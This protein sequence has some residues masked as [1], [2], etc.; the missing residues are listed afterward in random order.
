MLSS[1][2]T[3]VSVMYKTT[4]RAPHPRSQLGIAHKCPEYLPML[5]ISLTWDRVPDS[6][7]QEISDLWLHIQSPHFLP[8]LFALGVILIVVE[9]VILVKK[10]VPR[11]N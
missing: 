2:T 7:P 4:R 10:V 3:M 8:Q 1:V 6:S 11:F 9:V 5:K